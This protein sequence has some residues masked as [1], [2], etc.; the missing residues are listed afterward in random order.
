MRPLRKAF[1]VF[2]IAALLQFAATAQ[3]PPTLQITATNGGV[4]LSWSNAPQLSVLQTATN[5]SHPI[6]WSN[7]SDA[8]FTTNF[9]AST[10]SPRQ[11][12]RI[13]QVLP[14]FQ[15]A[16]FYNVNMEIDPGNVMLIREPVFC[17]AGIWA[18]SSSLTFLSSVEAAGIISTNTIDPFS[19]NYTGN[20]PPTFEGQIITNAGPLDLLNGGANPTSTNF[21]RAMLD[22]PPVSLGLP[23]PA[24]LQASNQVYIYNTVDLIISNSATGI[25]GSSTYGSNIIIY[26]ENQYNAPYISPVTNDLV[27]I[28]TKIIGRTTNYSTNFFYSFVTNVTFYDYRE[29]DTVQAVQID[30]AKF[31]KWLTNTASGGGQFWN[32]ENTSGATAKGHNLDSIYVYNNVPLTT[33][34]LPAVRI[35]NGAQ[36]PSADG[37]TIATPQPLYVLGNYNLQTNGGSPVLNSANT[38]STYPAALMADAITVLS[39]EWNDSYTAATSL[40]SRQAAATTVNAATLEGIVPSDPNGAYLRQRRQPKSLTDCR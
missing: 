20:P 32:L 37:L 25:N 3:T 27:A 19:Y 34:Q 18:G 7:V 40:F 16:I 31:N 28:T 15:F 22:L 24:A 30:V 39:G 4:T 17:N 21:F 13:A 26:Y 10:A 1:L 33:N 14:L 6:L 5:L 9:T 11:F 8:E 35:V 12:F 38:A 2:I 36:L 23:N 29:S